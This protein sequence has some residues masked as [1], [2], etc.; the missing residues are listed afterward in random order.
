MGD[1]EGAP[2]SSSAEAKLTAESGKNPLKA[3]RGDGASVGKVEV[4][5]SD[6]W[7]SLLPPWPEHAESNAKRGASAAATKAPAPASA[8]S[9]EVTYAAPSQAWAALIPDY[10]GT[11]AKASAAPAAASPAPKAASAT[12]ASSATA[13]PAASGVGPRDPFFC[14]LANGPLAIFAMYSTCVSVRALLLASDGA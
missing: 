1:E 14:V 7:E 12:K 8:S 6:V 9:A 5:P 11:A 2:A 10:A 13:T 3:S 4:Q